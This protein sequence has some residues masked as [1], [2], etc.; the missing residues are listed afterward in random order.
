MAV[1]EYAAMAQQLK[2]YTATG[3]NT[4]I[5]SATCSWSALAGARAI[6]IL[7]AEATNAQ[8]WPRIEQVD[9]VQYT[10][11]GPKGS[12]IQGMHLAFGA[13]SWMMSWNHHVSQLE[14]YI[15][16]MI[17]TTRVLRVQ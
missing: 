2:Q 4:T 16:R 6:A 5:G 17:A 12:R 9:S 13:T 3:P 7:T 1:I 15:L 8:I 11:P 14:H 10:S